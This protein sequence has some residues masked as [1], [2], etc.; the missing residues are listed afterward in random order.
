VILGSKT[1]AMV[2]AAPSELVFQFKAIFRRRIRYRHDSGIV[3]ESVDRFGV[4]IDFL[5]AL[6]DL[7]L[8]AEIKFEKSSRDAW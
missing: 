1:A 6:A 7:F 2:V 5:C 3:G 8:R 4:A